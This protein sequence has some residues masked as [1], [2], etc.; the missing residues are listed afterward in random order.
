LSS[1][2]LLRALA[3]YGTPA[4]LAADPAAL[5]RLRAWGGHYLKAAQAEALLASARTTVGVPAGEWTCRRLQESATRIRE[6]RQVMARSRRQLRRLAQGHPILEAQ[7]AV[8]GLPTACVIWS[9]LGDPNAY[10]SAGA[11]RKAMGLNLKERSSGVHQGQLRLS[12]RGPSRVRQW[13]Y[14]AAL[15]LVQK[16]GVRSWYEAKKARDANEAKRALVAVMRRLAL[17][18]H[19][20]GTGNEPF[21]VRRLFPGK[22]WRAA[23]RQSC[24]SSK[25]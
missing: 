9:C 10:E 21:E 7:G 25:E 24:G 8:V 15:R 11:Y 22:V 19:A 3:H 17:A 13:L 2:T 5:P 4:Q 12:K 23:Q 16:A 6:A 1:G 14:F 20:V 18:L